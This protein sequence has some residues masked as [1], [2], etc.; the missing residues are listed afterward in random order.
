MEA[1]VLPANEPVRLAALYRLHLLDTP[2]DDR[3]DRITRLACRIFDVSTSMVTL[4]D[5]DRQ[6]FKSSYGLD[7]D[8]CESGR[9]VSFCGHTILQNG[10]FVIEHTM[11]DP[12]FFDNPFVNGP[13]HV[14]FYAGQPVKSP[15]GYNIGTLCLLDATSRE[16]AGEDIETL[17]DM[18]RW[19]EFEIANS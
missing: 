2:P 11:M 12:R 4:I 6:W 10:P 7:M 1:P 19:V 15:D 9:D 5:R 16:F 13:P 3:F 18:A 8:V 17:A 14:R